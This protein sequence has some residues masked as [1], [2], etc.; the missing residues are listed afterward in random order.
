MIDM[1]ALSLNDYAFLVGLCGIICGLVF[2]M[3]INQ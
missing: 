3:G 2:M 1:G